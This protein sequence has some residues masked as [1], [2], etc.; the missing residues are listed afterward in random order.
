MLR[1]LPGILLAIAAAALL[2][3]SLAPAALARADPA[4]LDCTSHNRL[5]RHYSAQELRHA[6]A[7]MPADI[8]EYTSCSDVLQRA[9]DLQ[10]GHLHARGSTSSG[11]GGSFLPTPLLILLV[12]LVLVAATFGALALRRRGSPRAEAGAPGEPGPL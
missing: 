10:L 6:L 11:G 2:A 8:K 12:V 5:T 9:L 7:T 4:V 3:G 1:R